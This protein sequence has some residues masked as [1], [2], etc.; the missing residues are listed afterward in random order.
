MNLHVKIAP[1]RA[2]ATTT[3]ADQVDNF[4]AGLYLEC[5]RLGRRQQIHTLNAHLVASIGASH[6][7]NAAHRLKEL[8]LHVL[9]HDRP[10]Q[11]EA[12]AQPSPT[13]LARPD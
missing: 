12:A 2:T 3:I 11:R 8:V 10:P 6:H 13:Y 4:L 9:S 7:Q 1:L 5:R